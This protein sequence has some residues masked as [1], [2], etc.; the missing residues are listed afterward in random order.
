MIPAPSS[1]TPD[2]T[3][4]QRWQAI[5]T[6][7]CEPERADVADA[8]DGRGRAAIVDTALGDEP[9]DELDN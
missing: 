9:L 1:A 3:Q 4:R 2:N 5:A 8:L 6:R 7:G